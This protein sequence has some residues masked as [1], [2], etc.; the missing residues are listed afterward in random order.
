[1]VLRGG[2]RRVVADDRPA[3]TGLFEVYREE[4]ESIWTDAR[5]VS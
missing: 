1:M 5:P 2:S 3:D 4:F